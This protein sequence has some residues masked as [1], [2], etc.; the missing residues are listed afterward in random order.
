M[1]E[2]PAETTQNTAFFEIQFFSF[3]HL[4]CITK[5]TKSVILMRNSLNPKSRTQL[6]LR[7]RYLEVIL[8]VLPLPMGS[9]GH[10]LRAGFTVRQMVNSH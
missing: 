3:L 5:V 6:T 2:R 10:C 7:I 8:E 4:I 1:S 9:N